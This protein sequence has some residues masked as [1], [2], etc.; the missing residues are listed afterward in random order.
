MLT[1]EQ[2]FLSK[3]NLSQ[4]LF[5]VK[6]LLE[7]EDNLS[8]RVFQPLIRK[9]VRQYYFSY[10]IAAIPPCHDSSIIMVYYNHCQGEASSWVAGWR[11]NA[12]IMKHEQVDWGATLDKAISHLGNPFL[13]HNK[14]RIN[15]NFGNFPSIW[16]VALLWCSKE[17]TNFKSPLRI[18]HKIYDYKL[19]FM[20]QFLLRICNHIPY[21]LRQ[22]AS[23]IVWGEIW[24]LLF[25]FD[26]TYLEPLFERKKKRGPWKESSFLCRQKLLLFIMRSENREKW[27][28]LAFV[29]LSHIT[30]FSKRVAGWNSSCTLNSKRLVSWN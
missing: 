22:T 27:R 15:P 21:S 6:R 7:H 29:L 4:Q 25:S 18:R 28:L 20:L 12:K 16:L 26:N 10:G 11:K 1:K 14:K 13:K 24:L 5:Q 2:I 23:A 30:L 8:S 19:K 3:E 9:Q 17:N